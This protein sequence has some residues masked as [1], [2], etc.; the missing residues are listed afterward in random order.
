MNPIVNAPLVVALHPL[1]VN[2]LL[3]GQVACATFPNATLLVLANV[4]KRVTLVLT[5][6]FL[7][8]WTNWARNA[9]LVLVTAIAQDLGNARVEL[10]GSA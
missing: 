9:L 5:A 1:L 4:P 6:P 7:Y 2:A 3:N 10:V 8:V